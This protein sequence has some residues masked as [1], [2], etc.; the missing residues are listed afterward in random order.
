MS[1]DDLIIT[2]FVAGQSVTFP[3]WV[4]GAV[5]TGIPPQVFVMGTLIFVGG[6]VIAITNSFVSRR[7]PT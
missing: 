3:L 6:L 7:N 4:Y 2:S 1:I 5:K